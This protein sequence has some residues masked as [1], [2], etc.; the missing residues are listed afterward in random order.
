MITHCYTARSI[1]SWR[2]ISTVSSTE[3]AKLIYTEAMVPTWVIL[4]ELDEPIRRP[5]HL[6]RLRLH[7]IA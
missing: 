7:Q 2:I 5:S 3:L 1:A 6:R 4:Q